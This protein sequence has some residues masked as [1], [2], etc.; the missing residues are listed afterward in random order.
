MEALRSGKKKAEEARGI[1]G[2]S[3]KSA[4]DFSFNI[5]R[6]LVIYVCS[7]YYIYR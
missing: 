7:I 6:L 4:I 3:L 1:Q 2:S 5:C